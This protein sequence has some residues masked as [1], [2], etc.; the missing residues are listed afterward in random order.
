MQRSCFWQRDRQEPLR[1]PLFALQS[2][3]YAR[4]A[5][6]VLCGRRMHPSR[7]RARSGGVHWWVGALTWGRGGGGTLKLH[8]CTVDV[9]VM[10]LL[11]ANVMTAVRKTVRRERRPIRAIGPFAVDL[12]RPGVP[13]YS[14]GNLD[15]PRLKQGVGSSG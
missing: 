7:P 8:N 5:A 2:C 1:R 15:Y 11:S 6:G 3:G 9:K 13:V 12:R 4:E 10:A 14:P